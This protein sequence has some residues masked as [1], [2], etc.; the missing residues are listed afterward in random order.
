MSRNGLIEWAY[1]TLIFPWL[2]AIW[3]LSPRYRY[4]DYTCRATHVLL[5]GNKLRLRSLPD[6]PSA[7]V[8]SA[9]GTDVDD[10]TISEA[11]HS[12]AC[13]ML[14]FC[15][16]VVFSEEVNDKNKQ[17]SNG[18]APSMTGW[19]STI[20][21]RIISERCVT[22]ALVKLITTVVTSFVPYTRSVLWILRIKALISNIRKVHPFTIQK[23]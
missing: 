16:I 10:A 1:T 14:V 2:F 13:Y 6:L 9:V 11:L 5:T 23:L 20:S 19:C 21:R 3:Q 17:Q 12:L 18:T 4:I 7:L 8:P 15:Y 22:F